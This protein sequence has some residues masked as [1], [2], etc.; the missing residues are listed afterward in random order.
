MF[1]YTC[2]DLRGSSH[3]GRVHDTKRTVRDKYRANSHKAAKDKK[4]DSHRQ[5]PQMNNSIKPQR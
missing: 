5:N 2:I 3:R 4:K 1:A